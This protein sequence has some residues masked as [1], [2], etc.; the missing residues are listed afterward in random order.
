MM[1]NTHDIVIIG[2]GLTGLTTAF[3]L[4]NKNRN[5]TILESDNKIGGQ[6]QSHHVNGFVFESGPNT[7]VV[8]YPEVMDLF[9]SLNDSCKLEIA[10][11][12][13]KRR[14][15]WKGSKFHELPSGLLSAITTPLFTT[16]D[17]LR[18]LT[19]PF[20]AKGNN[21]DES[22]AELTK[23]RLGSS[24]LDY[25]VDPFLAGVYAANPT[26][27]PT[28]YALPKLY[29]L[30]QDYG[31]FILGAIKKA[32]Q[33]KTDRDKTATKEVFSTHGGLSSLTSAMADKIGSDNILLN[34]KSISITPSADGFNINYTVNGEQQNIKCNKVVTTCGAYALSTLLPFVDSDIMQTITNLKYAP[35]IQV[36]VGIADTKGVC[37]SA[38][39]GLVPSKEKRDV[40]G[41]L[42]PSDCFA[43]RAPKRGAAY[44]FFIGGMRH[45]EMIKLSDEEI[46]RHVIDDLHS[47]MKYPAKTQ[48]DEIEI[49]RH[50]K[51][52]PQYESSTG[53]RLKSIDL[54]QQKY[55]GL[56]IAGNLRDGIGMGDR[57]KQAYD[58]AASM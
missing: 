47:M 2:A 43:E 3:A 39:G 29:D 37:H 1:D 28:K 24:Y 55:P 44:A 12:S 46:K 30:E 57:I 36:G 19:E 52:I 58:I 32:R 7:G 38:F 5:V 40:L 48:P 13:A 50:D 16:Y 41:I 14:L 18:I 27:L 17:K 21:P 35:V 4:R 53:A 49:Y 15:I 11:A 34:A 6:I 20:R 51:A 10:Q 23:R 56:V 9:H 54:L 26:M 22:V 33:P 42:F 25:A 8:K 45:P 31:S